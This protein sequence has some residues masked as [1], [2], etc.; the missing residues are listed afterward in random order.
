ME[1]LVWHVQ[2]LSTFCLR[3]FSFRYY[4]RYSRGRIRLYI[5]LAPVGVCANQLDV[6]A[7]ASR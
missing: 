5:L 3:E 4:P 6:A 1:N 2:H 7:W